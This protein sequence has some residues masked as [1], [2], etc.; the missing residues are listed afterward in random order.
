MSSI[1]LSSLKAFP[2]VDVDTPREL[3]WARVALTREFIEYAVARSDRQP[4][5]NI[6]EGSGIFEAFTLGNGRGMVEMIHYVLGGGRHKRNMNRLE[7]MDSMLGTLKRA[8]LPQEFV[9]EVA[10][11]GIHTVDDLAERGPGIYS[12]VV[13][14]TDATIVVVEDGQ[15]V[16]LPAPQDALPPG[17]PL[18]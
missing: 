11:A 16:A 6:R 4:L 17:P 12:A 10:L 5:V 9:D 7:E 2:P 14:S 18:F 3:T 13:E 8:G 1:Y 15:T